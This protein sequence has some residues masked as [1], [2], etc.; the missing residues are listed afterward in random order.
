M[1]KVRVAVAAFPFATTTRKPAAETVMNT[2]RSRGHPIR[3]AI[4]GTISLAATG[5]GVPA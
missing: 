2:H 3:S 1:S 5:T 4:P